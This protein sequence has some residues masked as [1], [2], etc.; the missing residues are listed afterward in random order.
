MPQIK[1]QL[2]D[3]FGVASRRQI[4]RFEQRHGVAITSCYADFLCQQNG[5]FYP[6]NTSYWSRG[7]EYGFSWFFALDAGFEWCDLAFQTRL[8]RH[9][10]WP[11]LLAIAS[12]QATD[13]ELCVALSPAKRPLEENAVYYYS[14]ADDDPP[15][16]VAAS[17]QALLDALTWGT[18]DDHWTETAQ[19]YRAAERG[20]LATV[21][22]FAGR[23]L[24]ERSPEGWP[25]LSLAADSMHP[26][27]VRWL[28]EHGADLNAEGPRGLTPLHCASGTTGAIDILRYLVASGADLEARDVDGFTALL[29]ALV[30]TEIRASVELILLGADVHARN[31]RGESALSLCTSNYH[32][33]YVKP[34][35]LERGAAM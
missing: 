34:L 15:R 26:D 24:D 7:E 32:E 12:D 31:D 25:M 10:M 9:R 16:K 5:G 29:S 23:G 28:V 3:S 33:T 6:W 27:I 30:T 14:T 35:L 17:L 18:D 20:D 4:E 19:P 11:G 8:L 21:K 1:P 2:Q 22:E 13:G